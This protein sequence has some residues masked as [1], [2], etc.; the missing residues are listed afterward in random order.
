MK[1]LLYLE[2]P[3]IKGTVMGVSKLAISCD[4]ITP[5]TLP[6]YCCIDFFNT[7]SLCSNF[8]VKQ[9]FAFCG[10]KYSTNST[11]CISKANEAFDTLYNNGIIL[12]PVNI[13]R[14][15]D[16][17][18]TFNNPEMF[19]KQASEN[20]MY[21]R[22]FCFEEYWAIMNYK[23]GRGRQ[24]S[25]GNLL[26]HYLY[27]R[28]CMHQTSIWK[29]RAYNSKNPDYGYTSMEA[30]AAALNSSVEQTAACCKA[31]KDLGLIY[32]DKPM[33]IVD[34]GIFKNQNTIFVATRC[35]VDPD[36]CWQM[37]YVKGYYKTMEI[38]EAELQKKGGA[39]DRTYVAAKLPKEIADFLVARKLAA[40]ADTGKDS[41]LF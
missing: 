22:T 26:K 24:I 41:E 2:N 36:Y 32:F 30:I 39:T 18:T 13:Q 27:L 35:P 1:N 15:T 10:I 31:L 12:E 29:K 4:I 5:G 14:I 38:L 9:M 21:F 20:K 33:S 7:R 23:A 8:T 19:T 25:H 17:V 40:S 6:I 16:V 3:S 28:H 37:E 11:S 34:C